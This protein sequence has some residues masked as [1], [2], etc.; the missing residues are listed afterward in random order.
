MRRDDLGAVVVARAQR[1]ERPVAAARHDDGVSGRVGPQDDTLGAR[2]HGR[3]AALLDVREPD[4]PRHPGIARRGPELLRRGDL[5]DASLAHHRDAVCERKRL[6]HVVRDVDG[7]L[8]DGAKELAELGHEPVVE[9]AIERAERLVEKEHPGRRGERAGEGDTLALASGER[10]DR[11]VL[12]PCR[13]RRARAA[14]R[15]A[16]RSWPLAD[17][18]HPQAEADVCGDVAMREERV[19][20]EHEAD[21]SPVRWNARERAAV[22]LDRPRSSGWSPAIA[23]SSVD[24]PLPLG[25]STAD[26]PCPRRRRDRRR[27]GPRGRRG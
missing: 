8:P 15:P 23:R 11:A 5:H 1:H 20:L 14:L 24:F 7:R 25:P 10:P 27:R 12:A 18:L 22:E 21:A 9:G 19:V 13:A 17:R 16:P 2:D 26:R 3:R 6:G 4:E